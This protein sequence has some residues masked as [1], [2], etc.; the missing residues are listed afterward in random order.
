MLSLQ[1]VMRLKE[2]DLRAHK[3]KT[4]LVFENLNHAL[5]NHAF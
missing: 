2:D 1:N 4:V 3:N 5:N